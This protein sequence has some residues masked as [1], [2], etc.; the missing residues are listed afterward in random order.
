M[1]AEITLPSPLASFDEL[2]AHA[3]TLWGMVPGYHDIWGAWHAAT[4]EAQKA[5]LQSLGVPVASEEELREAIYQKIRSQWGNFLQEVLVVGPH[6]PVFP[7]SLPAGD[8]ARRVRL[9]I[10]LEQGGELCLETHLSE[11]SSSAEVE[12]NGETFIRRDLVWP[13]EL[14]LGYHRCRLEIEDGRNAQSLL[15]VGPDRAWLPEDLAAGQRRAGLAVSL[16]GVRSRHTW[17]CGD[18]TALRGLI[19]WVAEALHGAYIALNPLH[20]IHNRQPYNTS[21]YLPNS[22]FYQNFIYLDISAIPEMRNSAA[23]RQLWERP[24]VARRI[25]ELNDSEF[26]E[27]EEVAALKQRFLKV[28]F[29]HFLCC[30]WRRDTP[31]AR[32][33]SAYIE[34]EGNLLDRFALYSALDSWLHARHPDLWVWPQWPEPY[35]DPD[36]EACI[37][38]RNDHPNA[39]LFYKY[40]QWNIDEQLAA[41]Q[42]YARQ[43]GLQIGLFHDMPLATDSCG[44]DL[45]AYREYYIQGCRVGAPPDDFSPQ[46]QDWSFPPPNAGRHKQDGYRLFAESIRKSVRHGGALR[47]D[48]V[49]RLFRLYWIPEGCDATQGVY[50]R[51]HAEDLLRILALESHRLGFLVV[52]EDLG[53]VEPEIRDELAR[54][55]VLSYRLFYFEKHRDGRFRRPEEYPSQALVSSTTHDLPT[56]AGYWLGR[57][58]EARRS[59]GLLAEE[60][61]YRRQWEERNR[62]KQRMLDVL[63][64]TGLLPENYPR[65]AAEIPELT[66]ELHNA[67]IGFLVT[68]PSMLMT[69]NQEDLTKETEQQNL[70]GTTHQYPNWRRKMAFSIEELWGETA[71]NFA[72][73]FRHWVDKSERRGAQEP[74]K[75]TN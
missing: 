36:S 41:V 74:S 51:D 19:D 3:S 35:R 42:Q 5:I 46:G 44:S 9:E 21:P 52:G 70:P 64:E 53:T 13:G 27:Y 1:R 25:R 75:P 65:S 33:F 55:G 11:L 29:R 12:L 58:I 45:W 14:P 62:D 66:G 48:H 56:L 71:L 50:V 40:I 60:E 10:A 39:I 28:L 8:A 69:L 47:I 59:C 2:L 20:S 37:R 32:S 54:F 67:I 18:F 63:H 23:A 7:L 43:K 15:I 6:R 57:D 38:F 22:I 30:E 34:R 31:R 17:G 61:A 49:M 16:Y 26:V 68:T 4:P 73:M 24:A 72:R